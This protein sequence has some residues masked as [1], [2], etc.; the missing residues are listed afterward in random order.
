MTMF[1]F[2]FF[3]QESKH[4]LVVYFVEYLPGAFFLIGFECSLLADVGGF[5]GGL[6]SKESTCSAGNP[7]LTL[8][9]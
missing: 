3:P 9:Q 1:C 5:L 6:D 2:F 7:G 8:G 4:P